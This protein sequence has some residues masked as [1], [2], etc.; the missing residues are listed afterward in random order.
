ML[1]SIRDREGERTAMEVLD[2][3]RALRQTHPALRMVITGSIGLHHVLGSL[4]DKNYANSPVN[5][6]AR[7]EIAPLE[8]PDAEELAIKL[9]E[10]EMLSSPDKAAAA[11]AIAK[12]ADRFPFYIHHIVKALKIKGLPAEP[13]AI[14]KVV[15]AQLI[16]SNDP[17]ELLHYRERIP[18][19]YDA[20]A[21]AVIAILDE[22]AD[23]RKKASVNE[24]LSMLKASSDFDDR[25]RLL[26]L[27]SL[28]ER[29]HYLQRHGDGSFGFR[30]PLIRRWWKINRGL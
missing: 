19:Y 12:E 20:D 30:F 13:E 27:L 22:L 7:I 1:A 5:D 15:A 8:L 11:V 9:I 25:E 26:R 24:L 2:T 3:L 14:A 4:K 10:G 17:W 21:K 28:M 16:D 18:V 29:D 23:T 6:M